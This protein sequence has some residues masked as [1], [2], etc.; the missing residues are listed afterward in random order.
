MKKL[1][2]ERNRERAVGLLQ[3][4]INSAAPVWYHETNTIY[5][6]RRCNTSDL[7][8]YLCIFEA[9]RHIPMMIIDVIPYELEL[10]ET[11]NMVLNTAFAL[12]S[13][14]DLM[15]QCKQLNI[16][17]GVVVAMHTSTSGV[18]ANSWWDDFQWCATYGNHQKGTARAFWDDN[19]HLDLCARSGRSIHGLFRI[20]APPRQ[21]D[22]LTVLTEEETLR[23][24][25]EASGLSMVQK[26]ILKYI[27]EVGHTPPVAEISRETGINARQVSTQ[28]QRLELNK[29]IECDRNKA[30]V[31]TFIRLLPDGLMSYESATQ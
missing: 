14:C 22:P 30:G 4:V 6:A 25:V 8:G 24:L 31:R 11:P 7:A 12:K 23:Q 13:T 9:G 16:L 20:G 26:S 1:E 17:W 19:E 29:V 5:E 18:V 2:L 10:T 27:V 15:Y 3:T 28:L 21:L